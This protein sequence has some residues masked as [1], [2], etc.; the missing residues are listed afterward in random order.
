[1]N[2][3]MRQRFAAYEKDLEM[4]ITR[5]KA[6]RD[7][8]ILMFK[9]PVECAREVYIEHELV[10]RRLKSK[11]ADWTYKILNMEMIFFDVLKTLRY[12]A[13]KTTVKDAE[14]NRFK[15]NLGE[16]VLTEVIHAIEHE[17]N[18]I[19]EQANSPRPSFLVLLN[20]HSTYP[21]IEAKDVLSRI[22]NEKGVF[23]IIPY[24]L[25]PFHGPDDEPYKHGNYL[26]QSFSLV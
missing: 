24:L 17:I 16:G 11:Y 8:S 25:D 14:R 13:K 2:Q 26:V 12:T 23:V 18:L 19:K 3:D 15:L 10:L 21:Y 7:P 20:M 6:I 4:I 9:L 22:I 1:M 5:E